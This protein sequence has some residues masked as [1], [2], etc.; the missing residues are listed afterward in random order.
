MHTQRVKRLPVIDAE[1]RLVGIASRLDL[2][3]AFMRSDESIRR[4]VADQVLKRTLF[5]DPKDIG[6]EVN[7]EPGRGCR[8]VGEGN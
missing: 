3:K 4:E 1:G 7:E 8:S 6:V 5:I 2:L